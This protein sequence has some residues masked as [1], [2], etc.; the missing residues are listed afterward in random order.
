M[1]NLDR[2]REIVDT[3]MHSKL[4]SALTAFS[5]AWGIFMLVVLLGLGNA[6]QRGIEENFAD[7]AVNSVWI[8]GGVTSLP[9]DGL[10]VGRRV[11]FANGDVD[12]IRALPESDKVTG[13]FYVGGQRW[14][15]SLVARYG[16]KSQSYDVRSVHPD[17]LYLEN[18]IVVQGRF[19]NEPD[20]VDKRKVAVIGV[21][22]AQFLYGDKDP[23]GEQIELG[24]ISF[25][26]VGVFTDTGEQGEAQMVYIPISTAQVAYNG[27]DHVNQVMFTLAP[28]VGVDESIELAKEVKGQLAAAHRFNPDDPQAVW[29]RNN[30]ENYKNFLQIFDMISWFVVVMAGCTLIAG[31]IGISNI[32]MIVVRERTKEIGIRKALG[33]S[34]WNIVSSIVQESVTLT[35]IAGY[36]GM[37]AGIGLLALISEVVPPGKGFGDPSVSMTVA[38]GATIVLVIAGALA[39]LFPALAAAKVNPIVALRDE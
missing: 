20:I 12:A 38:I 16:N 24:G 30:A 26:V 11:M 7:D 6:L 17:H 10:P 29:V 23:V 4:R 33:A 1:F 34:A 28:D 32:M 9:H 27:A 31:I 14:N 36:L 39:G 13:R 8:R 22:V 5:M 25:R 18:T 15:S 35:A 21:P 37:C 19:L 2:W 3:L